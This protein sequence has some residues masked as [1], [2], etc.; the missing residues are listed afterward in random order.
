MFKGGGGPWTPP[1]QLA[2][3]P[4][5]N[6][7]SFTQNTCCPGVANKHMDGHLERELTKD[8]SRDA[9][10]ISGLARSCL[11]KPSRPFLLD[12]PEEST[13]TCQPGMC[14][15][16]VPWPPTHK[17]EEECLDKKAMGNKCTTH[18]HSKVS[19]PSHRHLRRIPTASLVAA[20]ERR[21]VGRHHCLCLSV[22]QNQSAP[23]LLSRRNMQKTYP[24][25]TVAYPYNVTVCTLY[26]VCAGPS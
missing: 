8:S 23:L 10:V 13:N 18:G 15:P 16:K 20:S 5:V 6:C 22:A 25:H 3:A 21:V 2:F 12:P 17:E 4:G 24:T 11:S 19:V 1:W 9:V 14:S 7:Q 26:C